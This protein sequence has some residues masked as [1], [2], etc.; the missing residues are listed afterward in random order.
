MSDDYSTTAI[1]ISYNE[2]GITIAWGQEVHICSN[3]TIF[4]NWKMHTFGPN[5]CTMQQI[6]DKLTKWIA[7]AVPKR[8]LDREIFGLMTSRIVTRDEYHKM[9][10]FLHEQAVTVEYCNSKAYDP[11]FD[12][13]ELS[14]F[15]AE[16]YK[17]FN[18]GKDVRLLDI[19]NNGTSILSPSTHT[20]YSNLLDRNSL[21]T[22]FCITFFELDKTGSLLNQFN[23][24][25][26]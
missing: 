18:S 24:L 11:P 22:M 6:W 19:M 10:G 8:H 21:W 20:Q 3:M 26:D 25:Q 15:Q 12:I 2:R 4:G 5:V 7:N 17:L 16:G 14:P 13:T 23:A 1:A 9:I